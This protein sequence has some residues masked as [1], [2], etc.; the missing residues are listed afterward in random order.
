MNKINRKYYGVDKEGLDSVRRDMQELAEM[1]SDSSYAVGAFVLAKIIENLEPDLCTKCKKK[2]QHKHDN[3]CKECQDNDV[4]L[5]QATIDKTCTCDG[6][7]EWCSVHKEPKLLPEMEKNVGCEHGVLITEYCA[8]CAYKGLDTPTP[9]QFGCEDCG[10]DICVC[11]GEKRTARWLKNKTESTPTQVECDHPITH[12]LKNKSEKVCMKC[13]EIVDT[14]RGCGHTRGNMTCN[15]CMY[16]ISP[17]IPV[18]TEYT[19]NPECECCDWRN[20]PN[21]IWK[22]NCRCHRGFGTTPTPKECEPPK[23]H[24]VVN[25]KCTECHSGTPKDTQLEEIREKLMDYLQTGEY[26]SLGGDIHN[27]LNTI[28]NHRK[29]FE[30]IESKANSWGKS[31]LKSIA[32]TARKALKSLDE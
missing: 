19:S 1:K 7:P 24:N 12:S 26:P 17:K 27:L 9:T 11:T 22:C 5:V 30:I 23:H 28:D 32:K 10:Q 20:S 29:L 15:A 2:P 25:G 21:E 6:K 18:F 16:D 14:P 31:G 4:A 13:G 3:L 8:N